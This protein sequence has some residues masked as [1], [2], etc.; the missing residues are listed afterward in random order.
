M[1]SKKVKEIVNIK[2]IDT[3]LSVFLVFIISWTQAH[4]KEYLYDKSSQDIAPLSSQ[5]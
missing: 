5:P 1:N 3:V 4:S 2:K